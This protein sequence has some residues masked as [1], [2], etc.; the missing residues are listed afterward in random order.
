MKRVFLFFVI[1]ACFIVLCSA[2]GGDDD[3]DNDN[4]DNNDNTVDDDTVDDDTTPA[5]DD[6]DD[7][8]TGPTRSFYLSA[9]PMYYEMGEWAVT[10]VFDMTGFDGLIDLVSVHTDGFFGLPWTEFAAGQQPPEAWVAVM[11]DIRQQI[12]D[13]GAGVFLSLTALDGLRGGLTPLAYEEGGELIIESETQYPCFN[14]NTSPDAASMRTAYLNYV[15]WMV[16]FFEPTYL[17]N[18]IEMNM[19][20]NNCPDAYAS[21]IDLINDV[22]DQEKAINPDL[23][24]FPSFTMQDYWSFGEGG[25]CEIGDPTCLY[26][27]IERDADIKRD[28]FGISSYPLFMQWEWETIPDDFYSAVG[29]VTGEQSVFAEIGW[30]SQDVILP[31]PTLEDPCFTLLTSSDADQIAFLD[32]LFNEAQDM[33][34]DLIVWWSLR[35]FLPGHVLDN[36]PCSSPGLWCVL[37]DAMYDMGML[38][39]W[40][41]WGAMG[42]MD[43]DFNPKPSMEI[44]QEWLARPVSNVSDQ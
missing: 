6:D 12:D 23:I 32:Y 31:F 13:L 10:T 7:N 26:E 44:W 3:D 42:V 38:G 34:C 39:A 22:Y 24:I 4:N 35:D 1:M 9:A 14:F 33:N 21:L 29:E 20:Y 27:S 41:M 30:G 37:Y 11:E 16:D 8:D 40:L 19:Y 17:N 36:C 15:R 2:C 5:D 28:R 18:M 25:E 43:Y